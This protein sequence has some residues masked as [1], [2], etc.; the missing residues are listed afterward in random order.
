[1][2]VPGLK[3]TRQFGR[4]LRSR[5]VGYTLILAYHRVANVEQDPFLMCVSP[6]H[7]TEQLQVL[8]EF[9][10]PIGMRGFIKRL[11][12]KNLPPRSVVITF[13]DGY[14]DV[15]YHAKPLLES[16]QIPAT[17]FVTTGYIG[18]EFWWDNLKR[19]IL[20][21]H[22]LP[23]RL[24]L[25]VNKDIHEWEFD[26]GQY[27]PLEDDN[28]ELRKTILLSLYRKLLPLPFRERENI[29]MEL[30]RWVGIVSESSERPLALSSDELIELSE[31]GLLDI[32]AHTVSHAPLADLTLEEQQEEIWIS[33]VFLEELL[34]QPVASFSY[35]HGSYSDETMI[36]VQDSG[37]S[38]ACASDNDV[39]WQKSDLYQ[40][41]RFWIP[42]W[43]GDR[44]RRWLR[45]WIHD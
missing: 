12:D 24:L 28:E 45:W 30:R 6:Q 32:G 43:A 27:L 22:K 4:W 44:F 16:Y 31:G 23:K 21:P 29:M 14:A 38:C 34:G 3:A 10:R 13:D 11:A 5:F 36:I 26:D 35:P 19:T 39:V 8:N 20:I 9:T 15:L 17:V 42:D 41:P 37:F 40:L 18:S 7:F 1:M 25:L 2:R 33:K